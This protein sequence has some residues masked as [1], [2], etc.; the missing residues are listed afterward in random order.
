MYKSE[1]IEMFVIVYILSK[2][3]TVIQLSQD[4][5]Q[6]NIHICTLLYI[7]T[8]EQAML[9]NAL[10]SYIVAWGNTFTML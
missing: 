1:S 2:F 5:F 4:T 3:H 6:N 9:V 10:Q 7:S 8:F